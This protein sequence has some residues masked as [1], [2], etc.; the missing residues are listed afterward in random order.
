MAYRIFYNAYNMSLFG[1][2]F[3]SNLKK[4]INGLYDRDKRL[5][6]ND[7][8]FWVIEKDILL[9]LDKHSNADLTSAVSHSILVNI[10][11]TIP[12]TLRAKI[13]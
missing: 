10:P 3:L 13:F 2:E 8:N 4:A 7:E 6:I 1:S 5:K 11:H 9:R 12:F